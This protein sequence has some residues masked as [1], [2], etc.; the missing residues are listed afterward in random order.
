MGANANSGT[1]RTMPFACNP[2]NTTAS[3]LTKRA[4]IFTIPQMDVYPLLTSKA[5]NDAKLFVDSCAETEGNKEIASF[6]GT[7]FVAQDMLNIV[8]AIGEDGLLRFWG[9][10]YSTILGQ[11]FAAMFPDRVGRILLD[12]TLRLDDYYSGQW[13]TATRGTEKSVKNFFAECVK[14]GTTLCPLANYTGPDTTAEFLHQ[15][16]GKALQDLID[17]PVMMPPTFAP[18]GQPWWQP[19]TTLYQVV[20]YAFLTQTYRPDQFLSLHAIANLTLHRDW[21]ALSTVPEPQASNTTAEVVLPW[22]LGVNA[23][24]GVGCSDAANRAD[25]P[26][27]LYS[28]IRAQ[29]VGGS[30]G[31]VFGP[32]VW[33]CAQWPF[34]AAERFEGPFAGI[35]TSHPILLVNGAY[36]PITPLSG[37]WEASANLMGSRLLVHNGHGVSQVSSEG[38]VDIELIVMFSMV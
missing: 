29:A 16:L 5:W 10:S 21:T 18:A 11:T 17:D 33:V 12:S 24:H 4:E 38:F 19:R 20:K 14:S 27:D 3:S 15:E 2:V 6:L 32:Q 30:W 25:R 34:R 26:E 1:G 36:D 28:V 35:N 8:D 13:N 37:A 23:F 7:P 31:D 22:N 9:R